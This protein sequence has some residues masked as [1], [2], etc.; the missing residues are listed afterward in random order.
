[1]TTP[2]V[3]SLVYRDIYLNSYLIGEGLSGFIPSLAVLVQGV[4]GNPECR[5]VTV[6]TNDSLNPVKLHPLQFILRRYDA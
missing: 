6:P 4:G 3:G 1:M 2:N 5:N